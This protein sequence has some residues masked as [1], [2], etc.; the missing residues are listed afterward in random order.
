MQQKDTKQ[1]YTK[2][3]IQCNPSD[4]ARVHQY[5]LITLITVE[6]KPGCGPGNNNY[7]PYPAHVITIILL[8]L[9]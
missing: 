7:P 1:R 2:S 3:N 5:K 8:C 9:T 4:T 6:T